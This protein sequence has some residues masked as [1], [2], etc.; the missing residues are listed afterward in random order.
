MEAQF[1]MASLNALLF[2]H[3]RQAL[4]DALRR[5]LRIEKALSETDSQLAD[6]HYANVRLNARLI[7]LLE[8]SILNNE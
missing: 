2:P 7:E 4:L 6:Y 8:P 3:E 5:D 1:V